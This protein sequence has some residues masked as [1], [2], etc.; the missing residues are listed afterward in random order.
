LRFAHGAKNHRAVSSTSLAPVPAQQPLAPS[1]LRTSI[2]IDC[3]TLLA[4]GERCDAGHRHRV[5]SLK[6]PEGRGALLDEV[7]GPPSVRR[8][9]MQLA[10]AGGGGLTFGSVFDGCT[11]CDACTTGGDLGEFAVI[12]AGIMLIAA[13]VVVVYYVLIKIIEAIQAWRNRLKPHGA[14]RRPASVGRGASFMGSVTQAAT[15]NAPASQT[16]CAAYALDLASRRFLG[17][18][19]M[20]HDA[21]TAG[22]EVRLEDG[23]R[24]QVPAG[25]IRLEGVAGLESGTSTLQSY[26]QSIDPARGNADDLDPLPFDEVRETRLCKGDRVQIHG[27]LEP[28]PDPEAPAGDYRQAAPVIY[29]PVGVV[30]VRIVE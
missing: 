5:V 27:T 18:E 16:P 29:V 26:L 25:R 10:K 2:C 9:A 20:L 28:I 23:R 12:V 8:R 24:V 17:G 6:S 4:E 22:F 30:G 21:A 19:L 7:W 15:L 1:A 11:A 14:L 3:R 13:V